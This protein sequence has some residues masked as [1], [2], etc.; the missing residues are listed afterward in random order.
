LSDGNCASIPSEISNSFHA[1]ASVLF[2]NK[3]S[4]PKAMKYRIFFVDGGYTETDDSIV[5]IAIRYGERIKS[6]QKLN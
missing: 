4:F 2:R 1:P 3:L 5:Q 6:I